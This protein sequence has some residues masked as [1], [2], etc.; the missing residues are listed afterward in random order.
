LGERYNLKHEKAVASIA[1]AEVVFCFSSF[2]ILFLVLMGENEFE[3]LFLLAF[4]TPLRFIM[5]LKLTNFVH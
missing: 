4:E 5:I 1:K 2:E 3:S